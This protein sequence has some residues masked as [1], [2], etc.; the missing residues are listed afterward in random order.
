M[1]WTVDTFSSKGDCLQDAHPVCRPLHGYQCQQS[2][3][4]GLFI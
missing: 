1:V 4:L 2:T 3:R